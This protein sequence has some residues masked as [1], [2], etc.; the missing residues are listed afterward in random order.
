[1]RREYKFCQILAK[2][3]LWKA[4]I[5]SSSVQAELNQFE[6]IRNTIDQLTDLLKNMN[7]LTVEMHQTSGFEELIQA[8]EAKLAE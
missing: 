2:F 5:S 8:V 1:M 6:D 4:S 7:T 3:E